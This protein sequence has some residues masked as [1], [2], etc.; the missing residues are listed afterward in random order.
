M[1]QMSIQPTGS[2]FNQPAM[3]GSPYQPQQVPSP[4]PPA[5]APA[6][7]QNGSSSSADYQPSN[8]FAQM[9][10]GQFAKPAE[11][12]QPEQKYDAL[13]PQPTGFA[14]GGFVQQPQQTGFMGMQ[15]PQQTGFGGMQ[16]LQPQPT[17]FA[18]GGYVG[19]AP[20][21]TGMM[22]GQPQ[23]QQQGGYPYRQF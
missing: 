15:Q 10:A 9:K 20:Q 6:A 19:M 7:A 12:A 23:Q 11:A 1:S 4:A 18:P 22:Y 14:P 3:T 5:P 8:I 2:P 16:P 21:Q 17:G 13:R